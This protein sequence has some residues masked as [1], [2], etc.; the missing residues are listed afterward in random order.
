MPIT[1]VLVCAMCCCNTHIHDE[2]RMICA[3][4]IVNLSPSSIV[5][6]RRLS[7]QLKYFRFQ[8]TQRSKL[9]LFRSKLVLC[10]YLCVRSRLIVNEYDWRWASIGHTNSVLCLYWLKICRVLAFVYVFH[11]TCVIPIERRNSL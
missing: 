8:I 11:A 7:Y 9:R 5:C 10:V 3:C 1:F 4:D 2:W 6:M